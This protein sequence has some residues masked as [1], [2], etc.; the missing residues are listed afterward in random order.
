MLKTAL[1]SR[2]NLKK[3]T[4]LCFID[5]V[6][7]FDRV[8]FSLLFKAL[9]NRGV[10]NTDISLLS[11]IYTRQKAY[12]KG[13]TEKTQEITTTRGV[14]QG[15]MLSSVL[16]NTYVDAAF[17]EVEEEGVEIS[18]NFKIHHICCAYDIVVL[19][20]NEEGLNRYLNKL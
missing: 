19:A 1:F 6:K 5:S 10:H 15:C 2:I 14:R 20:E 9:Q 11:E 12:M 17:K 8:E 18:R 13:E 16:F 3:D 7:A 4:V